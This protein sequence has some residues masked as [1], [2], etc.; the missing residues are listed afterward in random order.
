MIQAIRFTCH[1]DDLRVVVA[2]NW[3]RRVQETLARCCPEKDAVKWYEEPPA[4]NTATPASIVHSFDVH[5]GGRVATRV[6][7]TWHAGESGELRLNTEGAGLT[8]VE[9]LPGRIFGVLAWLAAIAALLLWVWFA[10][11]NAGRVWNRVTSFRGGYDAGHASKLAVAWLL[12]GWAVGPVFAA[13]GVS[14]IGDWFDTRLHQHRQ[15][16]AADFARQHLDAPLE[17]A[18]A[19]TMAEC[20]TDNQVMMNFGQNH[21]GTPHPVHPHIVYGANGELQPAPGFAWA[22]NDPKSFAV[23]PA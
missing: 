17:A 7:L 11:E 2:R 10:Y 19:A 4:A 15:A 21:P 18:I 8:K 22:S 13:F 9:S 1:R 20:A 16:R 3:G 12:L 14:L 5:A 6:Q 23:K